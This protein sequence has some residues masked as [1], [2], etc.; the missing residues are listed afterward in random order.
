[1]TMMIMMMIYLKENLVMT[2][3]SLMMSKRKV[4]K[5]IGTMKMMNL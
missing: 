2:K 1:M 5:M 3:H 4:E